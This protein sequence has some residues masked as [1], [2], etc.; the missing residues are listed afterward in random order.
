MFGYMLPTKLVYYII[1]FM[2]LPA[3]HNGSVLQAQNLEEFPDSLYVKTSGGINVGLAAYHSGGMDARRDP[4]S[5]LVSANLNFSV[6][7]MISMP[8]SATFSSGSQ[9]YSQPRFA[10]VGISPTYKWLTVHAGHRAMQFS[11][12]TLNGIMFLGGGVE[13]DQKDKFWQLKLMSG[14]L[15]KGIPYIDHIS[16]Q[17]QEPSFERW[18]WGG[19]FTV[20][21]ND[22]AADLILFKASDNHRKLQMPDSAGIAPEE[23]LTVGI[24]TRIKVAKNLRLTTEYA[25]SAYTSDTRMEEILYDKYTYLNNLGG[26]F[27]PRLSSS[28][29]NVYSVGLSYAGETFSVGA[30]LK[31]VDPDY[32]TLGATFISNDFRNFTL[33]AAKTLLENRI[34]ISGSFGSQVNNLEDDKRET[35][36]RVIGS[37]QGSFKVSERFNFNG[38]YSN[39]ST[40][41]TPTFVNFV[42]SVKYAQVAKNYGSMVSYSIPGELTS[43]NLMFNV[44]V[45]T[46]DVLN[47]SATEVER[48][49]TV[50]RYYLFTYTA[51]YQPL[52]ITLNAS[53]NL[54]QFLM[55]EGQTQTLGPVVSLSKPFLNRKINSSLAFSVLQSTNQG[56]KNSTSVIR[57]N[58]N[59]KIF[60]K[61]TLKFNAS[62]TFMKRNIKEAENLDWVLKKSNESRF[63]LN[64]NMRF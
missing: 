58:I 44:N 64:Y 18:G 61:H 20:G 52:N 26:L 11:P 45:Q 12:Y 32:T 24:N 37:L 35:T 57:L 51:S 22:Y 46:S 31:Q 27:T 54:T 25:G 2:L 21:N 47:N 56:N 41:T 49:N 28:F 16:G 6:S 5:Y 63:T 17:H 40:N 7:D 38:N 62:T 34:S 23:N 48:T 39:F 3:F 13:I 1:F 43:H 36:K 30:N 14:R 53:M 9:T 29:S 55:Q 42:D 8:F 33:N 15:A 19:M 59:W 60:P 50:S 4:F 10:Q